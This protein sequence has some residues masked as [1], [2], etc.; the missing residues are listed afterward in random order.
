M[1]SGDSGPSCCIGL[2]ALLGLFTERGELGGCGPN[3]AMGDDGLLGEAG[4]LGLASF[5]GD[6]GPNCCCGDAA[7]LGLFTDRGELGC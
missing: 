7:L 3:T 4:L 6:S 1:F 5:S 2:A